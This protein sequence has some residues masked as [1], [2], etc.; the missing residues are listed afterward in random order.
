MQATNTHFKAF[1]PLFNVPQTGR[2]ITACF[3]YLQRIG[4]DTSTEVWIKKANELFL[5]SDAE[6][7]AIRQFELLK[8]G[9][10]L[11]IDELDISNMKK[12][13]E[14]L[15]SMRA[16][17]HRMTIITLGK[18]DRETDHDELA[19]LDYKIRAEIAQIINFLYLDELSEHETMAIKKSIDTA[20][21]SYKDSLPH[22]AMALS[23]KRMFKPESE[24]REERLFFEVLEKLPK[25]HITHE[26]V[27]GL[28]LPNASKEKNWCYIANGENRFSCFHNTIN[29][30]LR[31][32][33]EDQ[34]AMKHL[35][36]FGDHM[37]A[38]A[39]SSFNKQSMD[40]LNAA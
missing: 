39:T 8:E 36:G 4:K 38:S 16:G 1:R 21:W 30:V 17:G 22:V 27:V 37:K 15:M 24:T 26:S 12:S 14:V 18:Y 40:V 13:H 11:V 31:N 34:A 35:R 32:V 23:E 33:C 28:V 5:E 6:W 10:N 2:T 20:S 25:D 3:S 9:H 29:T 19:I 7:A